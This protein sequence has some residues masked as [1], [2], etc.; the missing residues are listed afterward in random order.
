[1]NKIEWPDHA[2]TAH[3][4]I[5]GG[6]NGW[7]HQLRTDEVGRRWR[8][9]VRSWGLS[10]AEQDE[11][12]RRWREGQSLPLIARQMG[13]RGPRYEGLCCRPV[14]SSSAHRSAR[15]AC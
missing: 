12:W 13:K 15:P 6:L 11:V 4:R 10:A 5:V 2:G 3:C 8:W 14:A 1:M 7:L 9:W